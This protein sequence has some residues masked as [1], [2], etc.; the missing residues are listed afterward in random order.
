MPCGSFNSTFHKR[1]ADPW[2]NSTAM[3]TPPSTPPTSPTMQQAPSTLP[4]PQQAADLADL[5][6][7]GCCA[8]PMK[9]PPSV[10]PTDQSSSPQNARVRVVTY[11]NTDVDP[12]AELAAVVVTIVS[13]NSYDAL[14]RT[15]PQ[16]AGEGKRVAVYQATHDSLGHIG[17]MLREDTTPC[18]PAAEVWTATQSR[19]PPAEG[20][21]RILNSVTSVREAEQMLNGGLEWAHDECMVFS[22]RKAE[23]CVESWCAT[24]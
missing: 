24:A 21:C 13:G 17:K 20:D 16:L 7:L 12:A 22:Q 18:D 10:G 1:W 6:P 23:W 9:P 11:P 14:F 8:T 15:V 19:R 4:P 2:N 5:H 3:Q